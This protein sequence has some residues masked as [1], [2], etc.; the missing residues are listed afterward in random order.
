VGRGFELKGGAVRPIPLPTQRGILQ[1]LA[2]AIYGGLNMLDLYKPTVGKLRFLRA[3]VSPD[4]PVCRVY[5]WFMDDQGAEK[6]VRLYDMDVE[7]LHD[8][9]KTISTTARG[10]TP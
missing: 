5:L 4:D 1:S 3:E 6:C 9:L 8:A 2:F 10:P 7:K